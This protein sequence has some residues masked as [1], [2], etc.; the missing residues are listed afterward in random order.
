MN[1]YDLIKSILY[2]YFNS[3]RNLNYG[4]VIRGKIED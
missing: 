1:Y 4:I 2:L 3:V